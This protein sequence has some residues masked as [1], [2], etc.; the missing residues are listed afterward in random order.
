M[1]YGLCGCVTLPHRRPEV[2]FNAETP[3]FKAGL[4]T[5]GTSRGE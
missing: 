5:A 4:C 1:H 3:A 2:L